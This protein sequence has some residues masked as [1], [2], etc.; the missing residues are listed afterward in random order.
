MG[1][2]FKDTMVVIEVA[3]YMVISTRFFWDPNQLPPVHSQMSRIAFASDAGFSTSCL[4]VP[5]DW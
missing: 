3:S 2:G 5:W 4:L 1:M